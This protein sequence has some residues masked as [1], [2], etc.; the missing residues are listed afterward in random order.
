MKDIKVRQTNLIIETQILK[1]AFLFECI[2]NNIDTKRFIKEIEV[3]INQFD[4]MNYKTNAQGHMTRWTY[5]SKDKQLNQALS[6]CIDHFNLD[7]YLGKSCL[8]D[9]WGLKMVEH[10][11]TMPHDHG[12]APV[13]GV[14]YLNTVKG[15][16]LEL[17]DFKRKIAIEKNKI[18]FFSGLATH[19]T[20][21]IIG[22]KVKYAI[23]FN[24]KQVKDWNN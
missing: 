20:S 1:N 18:V 3:G 22:D 15:C 8:A 14:L 11:Y 19:K 6:V 21:R 23:S 2:L 17:P 16:Y 24:F 5:F 12:A 10:G 13:S 9:A 7:N 4:N